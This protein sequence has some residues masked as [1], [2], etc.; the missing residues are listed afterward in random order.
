M[1]I[2]STIHA[3]AV[4]AGPKAVLIRGPSGSGKSLLAWNLINAPS[5]GVLPFTRQGAPARGAVVALTAGGRTQRRVI[6]SGS[7]Y[8]CQ[9]EPVAHFGLGE[10]R[11]VEQIE[12]RWPDGA[13]LRI[14]DPQADRLLRV[15]H[16]G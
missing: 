4:L 2:D 13:T 16:P 7:G 12:V 5:Q 11:A 1:A 3:T 6:D 15:N 9:M 10:L 14:D 8:L